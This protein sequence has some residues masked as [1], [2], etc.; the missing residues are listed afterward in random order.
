MKY[1]C[2]IVP[3]ELAKKLK[4]AGYKEECSGHYAKDGYLWETHPKQNS[5][6]TENFF[7]APTYAEVF[8]WLIEKKLVIE[9]NHLSDKTWI[10]SLY[11]N[12][13]IGIPNQGFIAHFKKITF[14]E[15]A[16]AAIEKACE[17]LKEK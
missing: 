8:D 6:D 5:N 9:M 16:N 10:V 14:H 1:Y 3:F 2:E 13:I 7:S 17:I 15:A 12:T 11:D 4:D